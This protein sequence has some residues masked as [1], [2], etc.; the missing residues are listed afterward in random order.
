MT[1]EK[2]A[3]DLQ[4]PHNLARFCCANFAIPNFACCKFSPPQYSNGQRALSM[5]VGRDVHWVQ[6]RV[7]GRS[8]SVVDDTALNANDMHFLAH[9]YTQATAMSSA[10]RPAT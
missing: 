2:M 4:I 10:P 9:P 8:L 5:G 1:P 3:W 6:Q 7:D